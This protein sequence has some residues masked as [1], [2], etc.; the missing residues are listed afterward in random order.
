MHSRKE[1][2]CRKEVQNVS[3][4]VASP[5]ASALESESAAVAQGGSDSCVSC[6]RGWRLHRGSGTET[7]LDTVMIYFFGKESN[8]EDILGQKI[9]MDKSMYR[10]PVLV[11]IIEGTE[12]KNQSFSK[13]SLQCVLVEYRN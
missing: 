5:R 6:S 8:V 7:G 3:E 2:L 1:G 11:K 4:A 9:K 13:S 12:V 10:D